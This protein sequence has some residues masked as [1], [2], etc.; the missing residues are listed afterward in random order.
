LHLK[1]G[2]CA[3]YNFQGQEAAVLE[4]PKQKDSLLMHCQLNETYPQA[5]LTLYPL[6][7]QLNY[8]MASMWGC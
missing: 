2:G 1:E 6:L 8:E 4:V 7:M 5:S 3:L